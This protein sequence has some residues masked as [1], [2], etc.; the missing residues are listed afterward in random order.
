MEKISLPFRIENIFAGFA[1]VN[2]IIR[3]EGD[4]VEIEFQT[5]DNVIEMIKSNVKNISIPVADI[6]EIDFKK[7][8]WGNKLI[9]RISKLSAISKVPSQE[10]GEI[11]LS[12]EKKHTESALEFI[13]KIDPSAVDYRMK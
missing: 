8:I 11:K 7:S 10:A 4:F 1:K 5:M 9:L 3:L 2:G 13:R 12:I 6:E